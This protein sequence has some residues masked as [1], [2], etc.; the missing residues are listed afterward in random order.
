M[1]FPQALGCPQP[2]QLFFPLDISLLG[3]VCWQRSVPGAVSQRVPALLSPG[4]WMHGVTDP[5]P[6]DVLQ[7][8]GLA[9]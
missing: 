4:L 3:D 7:T 8:P 6:P 5:Q 2:V 1:A 9:L